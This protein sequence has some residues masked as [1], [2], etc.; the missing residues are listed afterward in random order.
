MLLTNYSLNCS[1]QKLKGELLDTLFDSLT[2]GRVKG[3]TIK[4]SKSQNVLCIIIPS[5]EYLST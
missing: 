2:D 5:Y 3:V 1:L 4:P